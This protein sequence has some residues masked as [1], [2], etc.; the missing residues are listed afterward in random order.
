MQAGIALISGDRVLCKDSQY[1]SKTGAAKFEHEGGAPK[2]Y[3]VLSVNQ[4]LAHCEEI[5]TGR[6]IVRHET[7]LKV[8]PR[9]MP[10]DD[11]CHQV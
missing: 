10:A 8:M 2:D 1:V 11:A 7:S 9:I 5:G 6:P 4:E 3:Q